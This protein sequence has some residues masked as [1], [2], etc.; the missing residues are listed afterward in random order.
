MTKKLKIFISNLMAIFQKE[1]LGYFAA[2]FAYV[3]AGVFWLIAGVFFG[4]I[5]ENIIQNAAFVDQGGV[6]SAGIDVASQFLSAY[7]GV[8]ISLILVLLPA[9]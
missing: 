4:M 7:L 6:A 8:I 9:L 2:P 1:L 5:L 3:I